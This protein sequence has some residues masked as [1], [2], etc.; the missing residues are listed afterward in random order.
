MDLFTNTQFTVVRQLIDP[1]D[2]TTYFPRAV[3]RNAFTDVILATLDLAPKGSQRYTKAWLTP[4][5]P[6]GQGFYVSIVTS[7]YTDA[8]H[9]TKSTVY[10]EEEN[11]YLLHDNVNQ[12]KTGGGGSGGLAMRD[13]RDIIQEELA[14]HYEAHKPEEKKDE[15]PKEVPKVKNYDKK[16]N[17]I[18]DAVNATKDSIKDP[19]K[20]DLEP[21]GQTLQAILHA[22]GAIE[23]PKLDLQPVI[24]A[25]NEHKD[26]NDNTSLDLRDLITQ[27]EDK[28]SNDI[29]TTVADAIKSTN[30]VTSFVTHAAPA[31][32]FQNENKENQVPPRDLSKLTE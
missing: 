32:Q 27:M 11:T 5:D 22:I 15:E 30:F 28:L 7:V 16:L 24:D 21:I 19:D 8:G 13:V 3:I 17:S 6:S 4:A 1:N 25:I 9:T 10:G 20:V 31:K 26:A 2:G 23:M 29:K 12:F 14:K 18:L